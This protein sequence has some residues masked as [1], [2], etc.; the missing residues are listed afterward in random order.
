MT[1]TGTAMN[2]NGRDT[3]SSV[4]QVLGLGYPVALVSASENFNKILLFLGKS[5]DH[6][7]YTQDCAYVGNLHRTRVRKEFQP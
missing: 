2:F 7:Y 5:N 4:F 6:N 3:I 1:G